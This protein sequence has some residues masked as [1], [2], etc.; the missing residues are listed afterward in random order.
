MSMMRNNISLT[1]ILL[2]AFVLRAGYGL[3][4]DALEPYD[5][6]GGSD[7]WWYLEYSYRQ[8]VNVNMEPLTSAPLY[9]LMVGGVRWLL[10]P[11]ITETV[12]LIAPEGGGL[13]IASVPGAA[14][15]TTV[16][17]IRL[18]QALMSTAIC[19][20][21]YRIARAITGDARA[22]LVTAAVLALSV[23]MIV[24]AGEI[25]TETLF[26]FW[27]TAGMSVYVGLVGCSDGEKLGHMAL[28][29]VLF[30]LATL[31]RA[32]ALLFP[33]GMVLHGVL[34]VWVNE[35]KPHP[36]APSP[37]AER[38]R[39]HRLRVPS[40]LNRRVYARTEKGCRGEV[41]QTNAIAMRGI[42]LMLVIYIAMNALWTGWY[43][44]R[45]GQVVIG[46]KGFSAFLYLGTQGDWQ[47]PESTDQALGA[48]PENPI[49]D[50]DYVEGAQAA[51]A[52]NPVQYALSRVENLLLT[53]AQPYGTVEFP[54][55]SLKSLASTWLR[56]DRSIGGLIALTR[57]DAFYPKLA[58]YIVHYSGIALGLV[59]MW[60][61]RSRWQAAIVP[62]GFIAY[63]TLIHLA[64]LALPRYLFP[65]LPFWWCFAAV[66]V[67]RVWDSI[68]KWDL[69]I[70]KPYPPDPSAKSG[71]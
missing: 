43:Y 23:A 15:A 38:G 22:G 63:I 45:W 36:P 62:M 13:D 37:Q 25:M 31:T 69:E 68:M 35:R 12:M 67:V 11:E 51:I 9:L 5:R 66:V 32:V 57:A 52:A 46:A 8:V 21:A 1:V 59:G 7:A 64:L 56:D 48:T 49:N 70:M 40:P 55:D 34:L 6:A 27:L 2:L 18:L 3:S 26:M 30:G 29:G 60:I 4:Q 19:Y 33:L 16:Q 39:E 71:G 24:S 54:G 44:A 47:G 53:Y 50:A 41:R 42:A 14:S 61:S 20:F 65:T 10:Q 58:I 17:V 28:V